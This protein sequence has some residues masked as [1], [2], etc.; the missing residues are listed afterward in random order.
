MGLREEANERTILYKPQALPKAA[1][2]LQSTWARGDIRKG[3]RHRQRVRRS[4][5]HV[6]MLEIRPQCGL[7]WQ[8][9]LCPTRTTMAPRSTAVGAAVGVGALL[10]GLVAGVAAAVLG[11]GALLL[12]LV[13]VG[14]LLLGFVAVGALLLAVGALLGVVGALLLGV[15]AVL[16]VVATALGPLALVVATLA[17]VLGCGT[18]TIRDCRHCSRNRMWHGRHT[19]EAING[20]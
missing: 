12:G 3:V 5:L 2:L 19:P 10:L 6:G 15:A 18:A 13:L 14:A 9:S 1:A 20:T 17:A 7:R 16:G 8:G 11:V 4:D